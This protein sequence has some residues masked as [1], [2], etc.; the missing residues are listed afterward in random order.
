MWG[1]FAASPPLCNRCFSRVRQ[2]L[3]A[4][5]CRQKSA[6]LPQGQVKFHLL[7]AFPLAPPPAPALLPCL[8][9][10]PESATKDAAPPPPQPNP[11]TPARSWRPR[12]PPAARPP[13]LR[14][15]RAPVRARPPPGA[16]QSATHGNRKRREREEGA[17]HSPRGG[18]VASAALDAPRLPPACSGTPGGCAPPAPIIH[19]PD[20]RCSRPRKSAE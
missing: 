3:S 8:C 2:R 6:G 13:V 20:S 1:L 16:P 17:P 12:A 11:L 4:C 10:N 9:A 19:L 14:R 7:F 18:G 5:R 15:R